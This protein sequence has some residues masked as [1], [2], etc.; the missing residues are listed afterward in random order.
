MTWP[1]CCLNACQGTSGDYKHVVISW[2][3]GMRSGS[4]EASN[5]VKSSMTTRCSST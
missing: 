5:Q 2:A 4:C 1:R 3:E